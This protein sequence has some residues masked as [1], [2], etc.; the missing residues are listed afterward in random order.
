MNESSSIHSSIADVHLQP[1]TG[2]AS[3]S[4]ADFLH[5]QHSLAPHSVYLSLDASTARPTRS[6]P[7]QHVL[8]AWLGAVLVGDTLALQLPVPA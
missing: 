4:L 2:K 8:P 6:E 3:I 1:L 7:R 5:H